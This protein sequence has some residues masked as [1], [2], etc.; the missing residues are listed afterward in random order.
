MFLGHF[1][2]A[3]A[4]R[5]ASPRMSLGTAFMAAQFLDLLWPTFLLLGLETVRIA[6]GHTA[7][8]PLAF[9][10]YPYSHSLLAAM[11]WGAVLG[12]GHSALHRNARTAVMVALLVVSHWA[13]DALVHVPDLPLAP[14]GE[15][16]VGLGLWNSVFAT[17]AAEGV[18][19]ALGV[20]VYARAFPATDR[21]G[22]WGLV[23][24][25][26][27]LVA[28]Y[29]ANLLAPPPQAVRDIAIVGQ[30]QWLLVLFGWWVDRHRA[31]AAKR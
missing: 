30:A 21:A 7:V 16:R 29:A 15:A 13:V 31:P 6:P 1:A 18:M 25:V 3:F 27:L 26:G 10:H 2:V 24:L 20:T 19:L 17:L 12:L 4:A 22:R 5:R 11:A 14:G 9:E 8:T 23:A 28:I